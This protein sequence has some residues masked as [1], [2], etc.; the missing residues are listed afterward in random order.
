MKVFEVRYRKDEWVT[1]NVSF[2]DDVNID[3]F[4]HEKLA[5]DAAVCKKLTQYEAFNDSCVSES[6]VEVDEVTNRIPDVVINA[7]GFVFLASN[8]KS[9]NI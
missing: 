3:D 6:S 4:D 8:H 2:T 1:V 7:D 5:I 9:L